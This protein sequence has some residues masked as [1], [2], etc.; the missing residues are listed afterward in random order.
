MGLLQR[1]AAAANSAKEFES[2]FQKNIAGTINRYDPV[3]QA[4]NNPKPRKSVPVPSAVPRL[5]YGG[6]IDVSPPLG[7]NLLQGMV[8]G[9]NRN[10]TGQ[11]VPMPMAQY[12]GNMQNPGMIRYEDDSYGPAQPL[13]TPTPMGSGDYQHIPYSPYNKRMIA[14]PQYKKRVPISEIRGTVI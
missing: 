6:D 14:Q 8:F 10:P 11:P 13:N 9:N 12:P 5:D 1:L 2:N 3:Y 7:S 4:M